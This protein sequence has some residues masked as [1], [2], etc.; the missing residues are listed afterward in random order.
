MGQ[1]GLA[2]NNYSNSELANSR[3]TGPLLEII[4]FEEGGSGICGS[5][6]TDRESFCM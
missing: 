1:H 6:V 2:I 3:D 5:A 4:L